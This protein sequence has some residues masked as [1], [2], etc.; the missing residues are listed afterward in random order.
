MSLW[1]GGFGPSFCR[2]LLPYKPAGT[3]VVRWL[4][5]P[6]TTQAECSWGRGDELNGREEAVSDGVQDLN[7][8]IQKQVLKSAQDFYTNSLG[9][10]KSQL[11]ND[12][13]QLQEMLEQVPDSQED[14]RAQIEALLASY[15]ALENSLDE[16]AQEH[17]VED[18]VNQVSQ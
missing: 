8:N 12:S 15:E 1:W 16:F 9:S 7:Q 18:T 2:Q 3:N 13:S 14:A 6:T 17:G 5:K 11:V 4:L 10:L